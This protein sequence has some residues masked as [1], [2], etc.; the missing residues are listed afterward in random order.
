MKNVRFGLCTMDRSVAQVGA[1]E[2]LLISYISQ[3]MV[4]SESETIVH[5]GYVH[6]MTFIFVE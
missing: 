3:R 2:W 6:I 5:L 4:E 1:V